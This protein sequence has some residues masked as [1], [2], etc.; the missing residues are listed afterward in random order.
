MI[1][2]LKF[3]AV[4]SILPALF[5]CGY[6]S[7]VLDLTHVEWK[8]SLGNHL[9]N[10]LEKSNVSNS[11][12]KNKKEIRKK[13]PRLLKIGNRFPIFRWALILFLKYRNGPGS[14]K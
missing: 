3:F 13:S 2:A 4:L 10:K 12:S 6:D 1:R 8:A 14:T 5:S 7:E 9:K 11:F